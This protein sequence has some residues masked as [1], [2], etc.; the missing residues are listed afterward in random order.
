MKFEEVVFDR[1]REIKGYCFLCPACQLRHF[2]VTR[3]ADGNGDTWAFNDDL[4]NPTV[5]PSI[6]VTWPK[7]DKTVLCHSF[8][9]NGVIHFLSDCT[10]NF[11]GKS[12]HLPEIDVPQVFTDN[13]DVPPTRDG[14]YLCRAVDSRWGGETRYRAW[15]NGS[16]WIPLKDGWLSSNM[17]IYQW[18]GPVADVRGPA[19]SGEHPRRGEFNIE[20]TMTGRFQVGVSPLEDKPRGSVNELD[21]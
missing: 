17:G 11:A 15:G 5:Q 20:G 7:G 10:H 6:R 2:I 8:V 16:W 1:D 13:Q 4:N 12:L 14:W 3:R 18:I 21:R 19:P 9:T